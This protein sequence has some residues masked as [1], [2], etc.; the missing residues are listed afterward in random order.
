MATTRARGTPVLV[1]DL[2]TRLL[3][4]VNAG[5][6]DWWERYLKGAVP[7]RGVRM[8]DIRA[9]VH[10]WH[11][12]HG[13]GETMNE[14]EQVEV[15]LELVRQ[16]H[17]E[18]KLAGVLFFQELMIERGHLQWR[19]VLPRWAE[20]FEQGAIADWNTCD[21]FCVKTL[22]PLTGREGEPCARAIGEWRNARTLWQRR[23]SAV[24]FVNLVKQ[25]EAFFAGFT[26]LVLASCGALVRSPE[27]FS[28]TGAGW[29]LRELSVAAPDRVVEF[30]ESHLPTIS[31]EALKNAIKRLPPTRATALLKAHQSR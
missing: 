22:G 9:A 12:D 30:L 2:Q 31:R 24:A 27:R 6:R 20:L 17:A 1:A 15:A 14:R 4:R 11:R 18:D 3:A 19:E 28:Q 23:A 5:T 25:G 7:F 29:V 16:A 26:E 21:W 13:L 10:A 8:A